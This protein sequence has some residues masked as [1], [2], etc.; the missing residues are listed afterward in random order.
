MRMSVI[1]TAAALLAAGVSGA[2]AQG[3]TAKS[4]KV[5][6]THHKNPSGMT[7]GSATKSSRGSNAEMKGNNGNSAGGDN[8]LSNTNNPGG[9]GNNAGPAMK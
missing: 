4:D 2:Y 3:T 7:T 5:S 9:M 1:I 6:A 8:S